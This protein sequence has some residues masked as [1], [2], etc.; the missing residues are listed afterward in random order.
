MLCLFG[1]LEKTISASGMQMDNN[2]YLPHVLKFHL[3]K[4]PDMSNREISNLVG[5]NHTTVRKYRNENHQ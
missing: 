4:Y 5:C 1:W 2:G 3:E